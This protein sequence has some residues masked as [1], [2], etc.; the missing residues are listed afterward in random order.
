MPHTYNHPRPML[1]VD[2]FL[3]RFRTNHFEILLVQRRNEPFKGKWAL[4]GGY[5]E[6]DEPLEAAAKR[7]LQEETGLKDIPLFKMDVFGDPGRDPRGRTITIVY[8]GAVLS[9]FDKHAKAGD[10]AERAQWCSYD[11]LPTLAFDHGRILRACY[12]KFKSNLLLRFWFSLFVGDEF[13][14]DEASRIV[15]LP[16]WKL[17]QGKIEA[18]L[19][20]LPF[21]KREGMDLFKKEIRNEDLLKL[22]DETIAGI[23]ISF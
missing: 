8:F 14:S 16:E 23:W 18:V 9:E 10:D 6:I 19:T 17:P 20:N 5:V 13:S 21:L 2:I 7:E 3:V 1:T 22:E 15:I 11:K 12:N 4:P